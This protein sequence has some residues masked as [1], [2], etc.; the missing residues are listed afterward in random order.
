[1]PKDGDRVGTAMIFFNLVEAHATALG[2]SVCR[3]LGHAIAHEIG[4]ILLRTPGH[5]SS[6]IKRASLTREDVQ[7]ADPWSLL[8]TP[9]Q[10]EIIRREVSI[11]DRMQE[12][13]GL[14]GIAAR[15]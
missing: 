14:P 3:L 5:S 4:H 11:R 6:G 13:G 7:E 2:E 12:A 8:F 9:E 10:A 15:K 1:M